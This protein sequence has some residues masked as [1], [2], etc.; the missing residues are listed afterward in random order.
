MSYNPSGKKYNMG[1]YQIQGNRPP[2]GYRKPTADVN[3]TPKGLKLEGSS[4][5]DI[6]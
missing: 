1:K 5:I 3:D 2:S 6:K 4:A